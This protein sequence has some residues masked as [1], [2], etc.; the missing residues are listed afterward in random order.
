MSELIDPT[1]GD[2][3]QVMASIKQCVKVA[4]LCVQDNATDRPTMADVT[5]MLVRRDGTTSLPDPKR[6]QQQ[7]S[8]CRVRTGGLEIQP[9]SHGNTSCTIND[10]TISTMQGR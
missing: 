1:L 5:V 6:P 8:S 4:L 3:S 9:Q 10:V 2:C 7:V